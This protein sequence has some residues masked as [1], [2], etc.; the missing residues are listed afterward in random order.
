MEGRIAKIVARYLVY[1]SRA[2]RLSRQA[3]GT[4][5]PIERREKGDFSTLMTSAQDYQAKAEA[6]LA[7]LDQ[8]EREGL[9]A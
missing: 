9:L 7:T 5:G 4:L 6:E 1:S 2:A 8:L 3:M